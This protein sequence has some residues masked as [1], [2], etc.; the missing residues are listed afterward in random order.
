MRIKLYFLFFAFVALLSTRTNAQIVINEI[1]YNPPE[2]GNDSLEYIELYNSG[3]GHFDL[4][5]WR[6]AGAILDTLPAFQLNGGEY[7]VTAI[8]ASAIK[9]VFG[10]DVHQWSSATTN[11]ALNNTG[12]SIRL[13]DANN[14]L[15]DSVAYMDKDPWPTEPDGNGPSLELIDPASDNNDGSNWQPSEGSTGV[16]INNH[17]VLGT[18][19]SD[20]SGGGS[21]GGPAVTISVA[22]FQY[23]PKNVVVAIGDSVRWVSNDPV[24]HN[25]DGKQSIFVTNTNNFFSGA[26]TAGPWQFD[27]QFNNPG[28]NNYRCDFHFGGGMT[29]TVSVYD[30]ASYTDFPL[31]HL[32]L[33][34]GVNGV[35]IF[36]GVPTRVTGVVHGINFLPTGYS[37]Y[38]I[39]NNNTGI[40]V[41]SFDPGSY[42]VAEGDLVTV[43]GTIDQ[44]NGLLEIVP[45]DIH[46]VSSGNALVP[47]DLVANVSE[48]VEGS[49]IA[50]G[51]FTIDSI[52]A[53]GTSGFNVYVEHVQGT[54]A[55]VRVDADSGIDQQTIEASNYVRGVGTQF[56]PS[57]PFTSG[58]QILALELQHVSAIPVLD[59]NAIVMT[60][61]PADYSVTF[62]SDYNLSGIEIYSM[63]GKSISNEK[64]EGFYTAINVANLPIGLFMVKAITKEGIWT[65]LLSVIR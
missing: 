25:V 34:D 64:A 53:T 59:Q 36:R 29:G 30:P 42:T 56:D 35:N 14:N 27:F 46:V 50:F 61:N 12:E 47:P 5:G 57:T 7:F 24:Q 22:N 52:V 44:F 17:E 58:Y 62:A 9:S 51:P 32:R 21:T 45:D 41:F 19:G 8:K 26:P 60:P 6:F 33:T 2:S 20:N 55:L 31:E 49:H 23:T 38:I 18:P 1:S 15:V 10:I 39:N 37:F 13:Y 54:K 16:T 40:N 48:E 11:N 43:S 63:D 3:T 4:T 28:L 65:S